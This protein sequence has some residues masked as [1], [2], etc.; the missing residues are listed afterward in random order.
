MIN[1]KDQSA[2]QFF[3]ASSS[4]SLNIHQGYKYGRWA[5]ASDP[6]TTYDDI[7][8]GDYIA[9]YNTASAQD[10]IK[11][12]DRRAFKG[13]LAIA[14]VRALYDKDVQDTGTWDKPHNYVMAVDYL[15]DPKL[16]LMDMDDLSKYID[17][18]CTL[19]KFG[20]ILAN[21]YYTDYSGYRSCQAAGCYLRTD[22]LFIDLIDIASR[23]QSIGL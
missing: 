8:P 20:N 7:R 17:G 1:F 4:S 18:D 12:S 5:S 13:I 10:D 16:P 23:R 9:F 22:K 11:V 21:R 19:S 3:F 6:G 15:N 14:R 2:P